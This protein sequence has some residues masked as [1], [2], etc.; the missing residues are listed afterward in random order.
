M[1]IHR[2]LFP[3]ALA[4]IL[5]AC[6]KETPSAPAGG[7]AAA[8]PKVIR[9]SAIPDFNTSKLAEI[10]KSTADYLSKEVGIEVRFEPSS[11]YAATVNGLVANNLDLVWYGGKTTVDAQDEAKN[12][13]V[14]L[15]CR[16]IDLKFKTYFIANQKALADGKVKVVA[17]LAELKALAKGLTFSFGD[18]NS[19]SGH[20]MPRWFL[21][22]AGI[23]PEK[24][25]KSPAGYQQKGGH[26][27]TLT[28]VVSGAVD[29][30]A[31][32]YSYY[33]KTA[34]PED[35]AAAPIVFTTP[36]YVDYCFVGHRR[37][38]DDTLAKIKAA[39]L[40]LDPA[41]PEHKKLLDYW[42]AG[43]FVAADA[44]KWESIRKVKQ[45]LGKDFFK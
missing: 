8:A 39:L 23:D 15:A 30:G 34:K 29:L 38:G 33:D 37:L 19:T 10:G 32:N 13:A 18:K 41:N 28:A 40:K 43:R 45:S 16:D 27:S 7:G 3:S 36:E 42:G 26:S 20:L 22:Q 25:F 17:D 11:D 14:L 35:K 24:D 21:T 44:S 2:F 31:L 1:K 12:D 5:A 6:S 4:L 9:L